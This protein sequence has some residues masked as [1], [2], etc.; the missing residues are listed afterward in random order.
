MV[1]TDWPNQL[2][3]QKRIYPPIN[4][5][6]T[7]CVSSLGNWIVAGW[8]PLGS[9]WLQRILWMWD[10]TGI[11]DVQRL[12]LKLF[13]LV[14]QQ[15]RSSSLF[16]QVKRDEQFRLCNNVQAA[17]VCQ[18]NIQMMPSFPSRALHG[19]KMINIIHITCQWLKCCSWSINHRQTEH[20]HTKLP[21][22]WFAT[23]T[24]ISYSLL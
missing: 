7:Y 19:N 10:H 22:F 14:C 21:V 12:H 3:K 20:V 11:R 16:L 5:T 6:W 1:Y 8:G 23:N 18:S 17:D 9:S 4:P 2:Q 15:F 24:D 13:L